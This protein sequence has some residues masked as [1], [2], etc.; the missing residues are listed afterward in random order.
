M[1][2]NGRSILCHNIGFSILVFSSW[3]LGSWP[4][5][6]FVRTHG[7]DRVNAGYLLGFNGL[8]TQ[9]TGILFGG[10][11][12]DRMI[13][14]GKSDGMMQVGLLAA[15]GWLVPGLIYPWM[16]TGWLSFVFIVPAAFFVAL[17]FGCVPAAMQQIMPADMRAQAAA[18]YLFI[19]N[20]IG[21]GIGPS[22]IG[23][24]NDFIFRDESMLWASLLLIGGISHGVAAI[25]F[26]IGLKP[27]RESVSRLEEYERKVTTI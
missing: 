5:E 9:P 22:A 14:R 1:R 16:P 6:F 2:A 17:P 4:I 26:L 25:A 15:L 12:A 24:A 7:W 27:F 19:V 3:A 10:F 20:L 23:F 8:L 21:M 18:W 13:G 11:L